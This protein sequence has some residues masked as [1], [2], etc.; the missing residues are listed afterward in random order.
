MNSL[1]TKFYNN[2]T[3]IYVQNSLNLSYI[4]YYNIICARMNYYNI[5]RACVLDKQLTSVS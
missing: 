1:S 4:N 5:I 2:Y 3:I